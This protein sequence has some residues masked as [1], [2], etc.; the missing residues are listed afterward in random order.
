MREVH[1]DLLL[2]PKP[3]RGP[4]VL[5]AIL[6][7]LLAGGFVTFYGLD[8][9]DESA[10]AVLD[11]AKANPKKDSSGTNDV[12]TNKPHAAHLKQSSATN[13]STHPARTPDRKKN[14]QKHSTIR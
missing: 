6:L 8:H 4:A 12:H 9:W 14:A 2:V 3:T 11:Y 1:G 7:I 10:G 5:V 13:N